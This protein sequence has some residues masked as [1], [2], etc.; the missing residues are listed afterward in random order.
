ML[1]NQLNRQGS[2][3]VSGPE[4]DSFSTRLAPRQNISI[5]NHFRLDVAK[6]INNV[7]QPIAEVCIF[8]DYPRFL[9]KVIIEHL[10]I[11]IS[12]REQ[13]E[14]YCEDDLMMMNLLRK[15]YGA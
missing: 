1:D 7:K 4:E 3:L 14:L 6:K 13:I 10:V 11:H 12:H 5:L 8:D 2:E 9:D 15:L